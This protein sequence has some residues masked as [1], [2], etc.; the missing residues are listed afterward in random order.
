MVSDVYGVATVATSTAHGLGDGD[1]VTI[2]G[3]TPSTLNGLFNIHYIDTTHYS[4]QTTNLAVTTATGTITSTGYTETYFPFF[5]ATRL[6]GIDYLQHTTNG[7]VYTIADGTYLDD[8]V[9][10]DMQVW[11]S[12]WDGGTRDFKQLGLVELSGDNVDSYGLLRYTNDDY[13]TW[14]PYRLVNLSTERKH[15]TRMGAF[16][17]RAWLYRHTANTPCRVESLEMGLED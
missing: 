16:R 6:N 13:R 9:P 3:A 4:V 14:S 15:L 5:S 1:P 10:V 2:D 12:K 11:T 17:S 7:K 8:G